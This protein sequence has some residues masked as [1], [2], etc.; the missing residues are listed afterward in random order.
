VVGDGDGGLT[1]GGDLADDL[2]HAGQ[3][4]EGA[5]LAVGVQVHEAGGCLGRVLLGFELVEDL[6]VGRD[7]VLCVEDRLAESPEADLTVAEVVLLHLVDGEG[8]DAVLQ[9]AHD[10]GGAVPESVLPGTPGGCGGVPGEHEQP[11]GAVVLVLDERGELGT[12]L[13]NLHIRGVGCVGGDEAQHG[14][15][16]CA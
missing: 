9:C 2:I 11:A 1:V 14:G 6:V 4:V 16:P 15:G 3:A 5:V 13:A 7:A 12:K 10:S 8:V